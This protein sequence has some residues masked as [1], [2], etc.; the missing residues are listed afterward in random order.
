M[1]VSQAQFAHG[2]EAEKNKYIC[3]CGGFQSD[4]EDDW[5]DHQDYHKEEVTSYPSNQDALTGVMAKYE[6]QRQN[7]LPPAP[8][9]VDVTRWRAERIEND[10]LHESELVAER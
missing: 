4:S 8:R 9:L 7:I 1:A 2:G 6:Q 10:G 5:L 3:W